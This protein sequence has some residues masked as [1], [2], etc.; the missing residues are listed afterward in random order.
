[1][2]QANKE[3]AASYV[4]LMG[5]KN[6]WQVKL[7]AKD[8]FTATNTIQNDLLSAMAEKISEVHP[9]LFHYASAL[10]A[11]KNKV[12]NI[13]EKPKEV[14]KNNSQRRRRSAKSKKNK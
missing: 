14:K 6:R 7:S 5:H 8:F 13:Q 12:E 4:V 10:A 11:K 3:T 2:Q 1:M 9:L